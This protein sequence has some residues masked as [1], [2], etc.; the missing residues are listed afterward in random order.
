[1]GSSV[2]GLF[3]CPRSSIVAVRPH[4]G[5]Y[6]PRLQE[7]PTQLYQVCMATR[8]LSLHAS[9]E[10]LGGIGSDGGVTPDGA[11]TLR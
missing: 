11:V 9:V 5:T 8:K 4:P 3:R 10:T 2:D 7:F 1:M 6:H